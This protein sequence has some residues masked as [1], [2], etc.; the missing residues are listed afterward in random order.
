MPMFDRRAL[1]LEGTASTKTLMRS[2][3]Q[4]STMR[5][6]VLGGKKKMVFL[7]ASGGIWFLL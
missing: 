5:R 2:G 7:G 1:Q 3:I 4:R 6:R